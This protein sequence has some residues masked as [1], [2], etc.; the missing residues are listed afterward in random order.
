M[1]D[2]R[3]FGEPFTSPEWMPRGEPGGVDDAA[4]ERSLI[5]DVR[6]LVDDGKMYAEAE[7]DFQ[8]KR[9]GY[10]MQEGKGIAAN[11]AVAGVLALVALIALSVGLILALGQII[12]YWG[13]TAVVTGLL[14]IGA[15][16][17]ANKAKGK[18]SHLTSVTTEKDGNP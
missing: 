5:D 18:L 15:F 9:L 4:A 14:L 3:E 11:F 6:A 1:N 8:K 2:P 13:S 12:T 17:F 7:I 16:V 10:G